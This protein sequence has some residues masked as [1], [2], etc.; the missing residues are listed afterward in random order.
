MKNR[1]RYIIAF[2]CATSLLLPI[3]SAATVFRAG[4][5]CS[6]LN[7]KVD[8]KGMTFTC[9]KSG[10]K[11]VFGKGVPVPSSK[12]LPLATPTEFPKMTTSFDGQQLIVSVDVPAGLRSSS[13]KITEIVAH[14]ISDSGFQFDYDSVN[15]VTD[16]AGTTSMKIYLG[17]VWNLVLTNNLTIRVTTNFVN[18]SGDGPKSEI[19][20]KLPPTPTTTPTP[21]PTPIPTPT[22]SQSSCIG[23]GELSGVYPGWSA[24]ENAQLKMSP[25]NATSAVVSWCPA[26]APN[27][28]GL[29]QYT[30]TSDPGGA[31]CLTTDTTCVLSGYPRG[32]SIT[33]MATDETGSYRSSKPTIGNS[34]QITPCLQ[35]SSQCGPSPTRLT[36]PDYGN[37]APTSLG[38]CTFA[39]VADWEQIKLGILPNPTQIGVEFGEAGGTDT[40]G[41]P[42]QQVFGYWQ[43]NGIA[44]HKLLTRSAYFTDPID[45]INEINKSNIGVLIAQFHFLPGDYFGAYQISSDSRHWA[46][47]DGYTPQGPLIVTW[48]L[49]L[50]ITW[51]QWNEEIEYMWVITTN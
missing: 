35:G 34:G 36:F 26:A 10:K 15:F 24:P 18:D 22:S 6:K 28:K 14:A 41:L 11:F 51:Q 21:T 2:I 30:V 7:Q 39:T 47:V 49:T 3:S 25:I 33:L 31:T 27:G 29:I 40:Q 45:V 8:Y 12:S 20:L 4:S 5:P 23:S 19:D 38:D 9:L 32:A 48:G 42:Y 1:L 17:T 37:V 43:R 13:Q 46:L 16:D 50:Q 44:G